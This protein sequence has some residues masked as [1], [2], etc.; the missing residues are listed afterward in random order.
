[1]KN[2]K[3]VLREEQFQLIERKL[4]DIIASFGYL[5]GRSAKTS[6]VLAYIYIRQEVTQ[7][8][9]QELTGFSLG[10]VSAALQ[11]LEKFGVVSKHPIQ[12]VRGNVYRLAGSPSQVLS[13]SIS[14]FQVYLSQISRFLKEVET[15]L[16]KLSLSKKQGY[17]Q[18][19]RFLD[20]M[21]ILIPAYQHILQ[22]FQTKLLPVG[23]EQGGATNDRRH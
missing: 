15:K 10:T 21:N 18:L 3:K 2:S 22:K 11:E 9:L 12:N 7:Q 20:E 8:L 1:M 13:R 19:R 23:K 6:E 14:D 4:V 16:S 17:S 5:K